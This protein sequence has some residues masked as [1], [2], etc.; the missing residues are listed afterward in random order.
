MGLAR[1]REST[2]AGNRSK[3]QTGMKG[4]R[5]PATTRAEK[6]GLLIGEPKLRWMDGSR[7]AWADDYINFSLECLQTHVNFGCQ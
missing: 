3:A 1:S 4:N 6:K 5:N 2:Y 7:L